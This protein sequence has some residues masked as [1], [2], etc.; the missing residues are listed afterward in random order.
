MHRKGWPPTLWP[1]EGETMGTYLVRFFE[2]DSCRTSRDVVVGNEGRV[3]AAQL[4]TLNAAGE[5]WR[6]RGR[7]IYCSDRCDPTMTRGAL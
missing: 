5:A 6:L 4:D 7:R 3:I 2:C 1:G